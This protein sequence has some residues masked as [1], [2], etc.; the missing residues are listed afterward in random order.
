MGFSTAASRV[1]SS[2]DDGGAATAAIAASGAGPVAAT[3]ASGAGA[4]G[5]VARCASPLVAITL[6]SRSLQPCAAAGATASGAGSAGMGVETGATLDGNAAYVA[7][8]ILP[9]IASSCIRPVAAAESVSSWVH[10]GVALI[11]S[12]GLPA[13]AGGA[14][15]G[16][17]APGAAAPRRLAPAGAAPFGAVAGDAPDRGADFDA[18]RPVDAPEVRDLLFRAMSW[19]LFECAVLKSAVHRRGSAITEATSRAASRDAHRE[20][21]T[22]ARR[23]VRVRGGDLPGQEQRLPAPHAMCA[24]SQP[25]LLQEKRTGQLKQIAPPISTNHRYNL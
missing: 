11:V 10:A 2:S 12:G 3:T 8:G 24:T 19:S 14:V 1:P 5:A 17:F 18:A 20:A 7:A 13:V 16:T 22:R 9:N 6:L 23:Q 25:Q 21:L 15:A 4:T